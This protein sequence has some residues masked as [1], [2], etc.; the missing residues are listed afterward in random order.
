MDKGRSDKVQQEII[1]QSGI[2]RYRRGNRPASQT[3]TIK[4]HFLLS[5]ILTVPISANS[6]HLLPSFEIL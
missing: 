1:H 3:K 5:P 6:S 2:L 4:S